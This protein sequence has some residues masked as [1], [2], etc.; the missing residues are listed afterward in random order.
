MRQRLVL[1]VFLGWA[2]LY[3]RHGSEWQQVGSADSPDQCE[4]IRTAL[5]SGEA[6]KDMDPALASQPADNP[7]RAQAMA[8]ELRNVDARYRCAQD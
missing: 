3:S 2:V 8:R 1:M 7:M 6:T 4:Q 5:V